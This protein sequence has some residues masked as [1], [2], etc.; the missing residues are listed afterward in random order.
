M[1]RNE[2][3]EHQNGEICEL[4]VSNSEYKGS[5]H[6]PE[7]CHQQVAL[8]IALLI[9]LWCLGMSHQHCTYSCCVPTYRVH[10]N[11]NNNNNNN[12]LFEFDTP[13]GPFWRPCFLRGNGPV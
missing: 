3:K 9:A 11:D 4:T 10:N 12:L 2:G 1:Q 7:C 8:L 5:G 6:H 13:V